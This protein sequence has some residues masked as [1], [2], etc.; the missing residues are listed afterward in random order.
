[1]DQP[2]TPT[3]RPRSIGRKVSIGPGS[4][5]EAETNGGGSPP[6]AGLGAAEEKAEGPVGDGAT[7]GPVPA[8]VAAVDEAP[9]EAPEEAPDEAPDDGAGGG[10][11]GAGGVGRDR[12]GS[13]V[14]S[15]A[16]V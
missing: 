5:P 13:G 10:G 12:P 8:G 11:G 2:S 1:D 15:G 7:G 9:E 4:G 14:G 16:G 3:A 6:A